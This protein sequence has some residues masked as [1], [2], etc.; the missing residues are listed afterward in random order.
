MLNLLNELPLPI[1]LLNKNLEI[2]KASPLANS[3]F[4]SATN[5]MEVVDEGSKSKFYNSVWEHSKFEVN[6][7]TYENPIAIFEVYI[8]WNENSMATVACIKK[9]EETQQTLTALQ[10]IREQLIHTNFHEFNAE[11]KRDILPTLFHIQ[12]DDLKRLSLSE[13]NIKIQDIPKKI[14]VIKEFISLVKPD[15][16]ELG[17]S[18]IVEILSKELDEILTITHYFIAAQPM[19]NEI[20][21]KE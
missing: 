5:F 11:L 12:L 20:N 15:L 8:Y 6:L 21:M 7:I 4:P 9:T 2:L 3:T 17:K 16:I 19:L 18:D 1:F 10:K 13:P 14:E